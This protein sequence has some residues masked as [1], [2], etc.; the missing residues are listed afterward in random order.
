MSKFPEQAYEVCQSFS[1]AASTLPTTETEAMKDLMKKWETELCLLS[2]F[3]SESCILAAQ[4][5]RTKDAIKR[6]IRKEKADIT[7]G[8]KFPEAYI[9]KQL[10]NKADALLE[11]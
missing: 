1:Q 9:L 8:S 11:A 4:D 7:N 2:A 5:L 10:L 6:V 3:K